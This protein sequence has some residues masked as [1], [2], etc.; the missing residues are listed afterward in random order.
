MCEHT[1]ALQ[2]HGQSYSVIVDLPRSAAEAEARR[3]P[4]FVGTCRGCGPG[5]VFRLRMADRRAEVKGTCLR[6][7][8]AAVN[9][10]EQRRA[11]RERVG[12]K[13]AGYGDAVAKAKAENFGSRRVAWGE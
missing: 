1:L 6:C 7:Q 4:L 2:L 9:D 11:D 5:S 3:M 12:L 8:R 13:D 10:P